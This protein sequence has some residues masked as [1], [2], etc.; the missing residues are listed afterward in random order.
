MSKVISKNY[1]EQQME[2]HNNSSYGI[3]SLKASP[4]VAKF[5]LEKKC[6]SILDYGAGKQRLKPGL[7]ENG[8]KGTYT[9]YDPAMPEISKLKKGKYDLLACIDVLEHIEPDYIDN[10]L[11]HMLEN[12]HKFGFFTI[13]TRPAI[14]TLPDGRNAH[15][16]QEKFHW[17]KPKI[18]KRW[19]II[20][21]VIKNK[22]Q[23]QV[24]VKR[25]N[26]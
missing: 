24:T 26:A 19:I 7:Y 1:L 14:K 11:D 13:S 3:T 12:T 8:Y 22:D 17:W 4:K 25:K 20:G 18:E 2:L 23:F 21:E 6:N 9:A 5:A 15:L 16:I 10:V